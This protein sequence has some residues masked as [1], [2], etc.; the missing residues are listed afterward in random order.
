[1]QIIVAS[2]WHPDWVTAGLDRYDDVEHAVEEVM[3]MCIDRKVDAF[4][5][6]GDLC[7]PGTHRCHRAIGL[8]VRVAETLNEEGIAQLWI[9][10]NHD[11]IEDGHGSHTL[12]MLIE[13]GYL[14]VKD[15]PG[16]TL[17][18]PKRNGE[19]SVNVMCLPYTPRSHDYDPEEEIRKLGD[20]APDI[21]VGHLNIEGITPGS[22]TADMPRGRHVYFP[23]DLVRETFPDALL[24][25]GHYHQQQ[26]WKGTGGRNKQGIHIPGSLARLTRTEKDHSPGWLVLEVN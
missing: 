26:V 21:I 19:Q 10:G 18:G 12:S 17:L 15:S 1:M 23:Y 20:V 3:E 25:N 16:L 8:A 13:L 7:N 2:D 14:T 11:V 6:A 5:F 4:I 9:P 24:I 22:E